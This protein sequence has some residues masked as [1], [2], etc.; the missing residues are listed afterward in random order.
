LPEDRIDILV[1]P[2]SVVHSLVS[3]LDGSVLAQLGTPDMRTPI[4]VALGWPQRMVSP[5]RRLDLAAI[6]SLTFESPDPVRFPALRLAREALRVGGGAPTVLNA[7]NEI[8]VAAFLRRDIGF[9]HIAE[10]V[11]ETLL[12]LHGETIA[13]LD[14][15]RM[16]DG[17]ARQVAS[18]LV[19]RLAVASEIQ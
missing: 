17:R 5:G 18:Q 8:A 13:T 14:D 12:V 4:A 6:G 9:L 1:H 3:Y 10:L 15:V 19:A 11:E 16:L 7:A 2:Q